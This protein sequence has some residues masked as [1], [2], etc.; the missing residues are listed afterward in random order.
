MVD[1][2]IVGAGSAGAILASRLSDNPDRAVV[3]LESGPDHSDSAGLPE[4]VRDSRGLGGPAHQ[5]GFQAE[6]LPG[7]TI[8]DARGRLV[9]G[10]GAIN[11]AAVQ[12]GRPADFAVWQARGLNEWGWTDVVPWYRRLEADRDAAGNHHGRNGAIPIVRYRPDELIPIQR[13]FHAGCLATGFA[14]IADHNDP[15]VTGPAVGPWPMNRDGTTRMSSA[16]THLGPARHRPNLTIRPDSTVDRLSIEDGVVLG[17]RLVSGEEVHARRT[18]LAAGSIGSA[19]ILMR[20]GIGPAGELAALGITPILDQPGLGARLLDH[21]AVPLYLVPHPGECVMGR[22]PRFQMMAR[23]DAPGSPEVDDMQLV[24]TSWLD[25]KPTP[26]LAK[27]AGTDVVAALRVALLCPRGHG[28]MRLVSADPLTPP[29]IELN[30]TAEPEDMQRFLAGLRLAWRV[31]TTPAMA[32]AYERIVG[33]DE[34]TISSDAAL[35]DYARANVGTYCHALGTVPMGADGDTSA[36]LDQRCRVRGVDGIS[37]VD[38]AVFPVVPRVV[39][40]LTIMMI[41][42]RVAAWLAEE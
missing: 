9:G 37:V 30:F 21:S 27:A 10:T 15:A 17:V 14:D 33:L 8:A 38:A 5:W 11:A 34:A 42:E 19:A 26:T 7:R 20:S 41:A 32:A 18:V 12:W 25:L 22:D 24:L 4:D 13:A 16:L 36:V 2:L 28:R 6:V 31:V 29:R 40:H 1:I 39:G 3:L 23:F 35:A